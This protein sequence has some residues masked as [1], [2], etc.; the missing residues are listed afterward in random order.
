MGRSRWQHIAQTHFYKEISAETRCVSDPANKS[1][2]TGTSEG[3]LKRLDPVCLGVIWGQ[4]R[5]Q[6]DAT[7]SAHFGSLVFRRGDVSRMSVLLHKRLFRGGFSPRTNMSGS[8]RW[9]LI[10]AGVLSVWTPA[11]GGSLRG[12]SAHLRDIMRRPVGFS[13]PH[14]LLHQFASGGGGQPQLHF[15]QHLDSMKVLRGAVKEINKSKQ[16]EDVRE[17]GAVF[18][19]KFSHQVHEHQLL[20]NFFTLQKKFLL[21]QSYRAH[22][23]GTFQQMFVREEINL[24]QES[25]RQTSTGDPPSENCFHTRSPD[26]REGNM[27]EGR[28]RLH[29]FHRWFIDV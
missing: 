16:A 3:E 12:K 1:A 25:I 27:A 9:L 22:Q 26:S 5:F 2:F 4:S 14:S 28:S 13:S 21:N 24:L 10:L 18:G 29:I 20:C 6:R 19:S 7:F 8:R 23:P 11:S 17:S 15:C